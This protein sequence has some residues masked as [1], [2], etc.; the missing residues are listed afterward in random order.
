MAVI[1]NFFG[2]KCV[3]LNNYFF[4][5]YPLASSTAPGFLAEVSKNHI[6][7]Y[8]SNKS[9]WVRNN[10]GS[11]IFVTDGSLKPGERSSLSIGQE[12][13][14]GENW[15][16][17]WLVLDTT[18]PRKATVFLSDNDDWCVHGEGR[19]LHLRNGDWVIAEQY[20]WCLCAAEKG[21]PEYNLDVSE[22]IQMAAPIVYFEVSTDEEHVVACIEIETEKISLYERAHHYLLVALARVKLQDY[23]KGYDIS[24]C[25]WVDMEDLCKML[26]MDAAHINIQIYRARKQI[27][28][29]VFLDDDF[30]DIIERRLGSV[31]LGDW[32]FKIVSGSRLEG[33][34]KTA[35]CS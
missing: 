20:Q 26:G 22:S 11:M 5:K 14:F 19:P 4:I 6:V 25:G 29:A 18:P 10:S 1:E 34:M 9:W 35:G 30:P 7:L 23:C 13:I 8:W 31:R 12:L 32:G 2:T 3:I 27:A 16:S 24:A 33:E 21:L 28:G 15:H 17:R